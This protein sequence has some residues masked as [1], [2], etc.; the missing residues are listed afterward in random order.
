VADLDR[1]QEFYTSLFDLEPMLRDE[2]M[3]A[4]SVPGRQVLLLFRERMSNEPSVT[5]F[6]LIPPHGSHGVQHVCFA[7]ELEDLPGWEA[8]LAQAGI[9]TESRLV[10]PQGAVS[11]YFRD[12]DGHSVE[13]S[14][15]RLWPN[16]RG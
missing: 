13:L 7:I 16:D 3:A 14:T 8:R 2:R 15:P 5:P 10:W 12:P 1:A 11:V 6:G 9:A 4:L